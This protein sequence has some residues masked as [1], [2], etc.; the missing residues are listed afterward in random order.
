MSFGARRFPGSGPI[1]TNM[2]VWSSHKERFDGIGL[3]I[4]EVDRA[5]MVVTARAIHPRP[6][7]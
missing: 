1:C 7:A 3:T 4:M 6:D 2:T 5:G